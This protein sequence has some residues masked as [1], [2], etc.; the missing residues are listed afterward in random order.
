[1]VDIN[2]TEKATILVVD[3]APDNLA[4]LSNLLKNDYKVKIAN[5]GERAL[6]IAMSDTPPNLILLDIV[7][8]G[9]DG[10]EVCQRLK[11]DPRT[12]NIPV[13]FVTART[14]VADERKG[15]ELGA[16]DYITKPISPPIVM[17]R[18]KN[19]LALQ[20]RSSREEVEARHDWLKKSLERFV[21][22]L[23]QPQ[24]QDKTTVA[25]DIENRKAVCDK[26]EILLVNG[27]T[28][29]VDVMDENA[30]LLDEAYPNHSHEIDNY[31]RCFDFEA[32]LASLRA[33]TAA[34]L[35]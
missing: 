20:E 14:E 8:P 23:E 17:V 26:L 5:S 2:C 22:Q 35:P 10:Y 9:M 21:T 32:A 19:H 28:D 25:A 27:D 18:V 30:E 11:R 12:V 29:A 7:M 34:T 13:I 4:L 24:K 31:I 15:L 16:I 1:M 6:Q 3:D 33:A